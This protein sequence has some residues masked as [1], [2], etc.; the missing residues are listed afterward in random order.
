M[1]FFWNL[2]YL[3]ICFI[4]NIKRIQRYIVYAVVY[5]MILYTKSFFRITQK[6]KKVDCW[7]RIKEKVIQNNILC[8]IFQYHQNQ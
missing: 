7:L 4:R 5:S 3:F 8:N 6:F 2:I 1:K